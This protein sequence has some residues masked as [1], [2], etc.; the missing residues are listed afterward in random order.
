VASSLEVTIASLAIHFI[1]P[2]IIVFG[3][4]YKFQAITFRAI[5]GESYFK[6]VL[7]IEYPKL[8]LGIVTA[9]RHKYPLGFFFELLVCVGGVL[10]HTR[11]MFF[12]EF[13]DTTP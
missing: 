5:V 12:Q 4:L 3:L 1:G 7:D 11:V 13:M 8:F 2:H 10:D 9:I 6:R